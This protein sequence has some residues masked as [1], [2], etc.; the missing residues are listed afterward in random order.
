MLPASPCLRAYHP[1]PVGRLPPCLSS[2]LPAGVPAD[3]APSCLPVS[4]AAFYSLELRGL[5]HKID[6]KNFDKFNLEN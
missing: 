3:I 4:L 2:Y 1:I 5:S 6:F